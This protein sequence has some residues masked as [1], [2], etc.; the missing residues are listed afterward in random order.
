MIE[1]IIKSEIELFLSETR[2][3]DL[4]YE[5]LLFNKNLNET[6][7]WGDITRYVNKIVNKRS[8]LQNAIKRFNM[9]NNKLMKKYLLMIIFTIITTFSAGKE[10]QDTS[11]SEIKKD[12]FEKL[13]AA[14]AKRDSI[15]YAE[16]LEMI[17]GFKKNKIKTFVTSDQGKEFIKTHESYRDRAYKL[18]DGMITI[19]YGHAERI[20]DSQFEVGQKISKQEAEQLF[21]EDLKVAENGVKRILLKLIDKNPE[22]DINQ[23]M[24]DAMVSMAFNMGVRGLA[25]T[26]FV[27]ALANSDNITN[28]A[29]LIKTSRVGNWGGLKKRR[30]GEYQLFVSDIVTSSVSKDYI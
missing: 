11:F 25:T 5:N 8:V 19:G 21:R 18:G 26:E 6:I 20:G 22:M 16:A 29:E 13:A 15:N 7:N 9:S 27:D 12:E 28:A 23:S 17:K 10:D 1:K 4:F 2:K 30:Q 24:F 3:N 14:Q